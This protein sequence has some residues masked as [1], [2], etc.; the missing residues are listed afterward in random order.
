M[1]YSILR[2]SLLVAVS[3]KYRISTLVK[4]VILFFQ[5]EVRRKPP[6]KVR[7]KQSVGKDMGDGWETKR[8]RAKGHSDWAILML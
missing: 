2:S 1:K 7:F 8:S 4:E 6:A 3:F 5:E